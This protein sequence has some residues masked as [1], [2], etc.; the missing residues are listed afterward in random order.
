MMDLI[1]KAKDVDPGTVIRLQSANEGT[2]PD[3]SEWAEQSGNKLIE[4]TDRDDHW[5]LYVRIND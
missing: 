2:E 1:G 5:D 3:V 4:V